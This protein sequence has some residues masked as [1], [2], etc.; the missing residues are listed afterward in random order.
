[1]LILF[2]IIINACE[3]KYD[4]ACCKEDCPFCGPCK[5]NHSYGDFEENCCSN[6]IL[7]S[8]LLCNETVPPCILQIHMNNLNRLIEFFKGELMIV[9]PV[10][11]SLGLVVLFIF[12]SMCIFGNKRPPVKYKFIK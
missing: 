12:Y 1:M 7:N 3:I 2:L 11:V 10:S 9:I 4:I 5:A 6:I 8:N